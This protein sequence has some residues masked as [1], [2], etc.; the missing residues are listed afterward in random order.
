MFQQ[1]QTAR[2]H[3]Q[4]VSFE[5]NGRFLHNFVT[6]LQVAGRVVRKIGTIVLHG[7]HLFVAGAEQPRSAQKAHWWE[8][9]ES[10]DDRFNR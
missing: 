2:D 1:T 6:I 5:G 8:S 7:F 3:D 9:R 10:V 4:Q